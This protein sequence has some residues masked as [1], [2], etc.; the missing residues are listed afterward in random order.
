MII[1]W[2][3]KERVRKLEGRIELSN[4]LFKSIASDLEE[5]METL[6]KEGV[7]IVRDPYWK[8]AYDLGRC[9]GWSDLD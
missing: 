8:L 4:Y 5:I 3:D 9:K 6:K 7:D 2:T 1:G